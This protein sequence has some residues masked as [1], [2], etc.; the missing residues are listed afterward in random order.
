MSVNTEHQHINYLVT[1]YVLEL[2]PRA[3]HEAASRHIAHC[4]NCR[5]AVMRERQIG[6]AVK[7]TI[8]KASGIERRSLARAMPTMSQKNRFRRI[9]DQGQ[10]QI[11][12]ACCL[13][14]LAFASVGLQLRLH[15]NNWT[16]TS[17]AI[18]ST[19]VM[20][21]ETPTATHLATTEFSDTSSPMA[22]TPA[23]E[24]IS[25]L[26]K[27]ALAPVA[28]YAAQITSLSLQ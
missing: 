11:L 10:V 6:V 20:I 16:A 17:P 23:N 8:S 19:T 21:T 26:P 18:F 1:D 24:I 2:L 15:Q 4:G 5:R 13:L 25:P 14:L 22:P 7:Q 12:L 3:E 9:I 28:G 27:A